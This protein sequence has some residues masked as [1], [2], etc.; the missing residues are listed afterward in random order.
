MIP[1]YFL[2]HSK[3]ILFFTGLFFLFTAK[4]Q[5]QQ[6]VAVPMAQPT[7]DST[8]PIEI[9]FARS[10][11]IFTPPNGTELQTLAGNAAVKQG[12]TILKGDSIVLNPL[13]GI[14]EVFGNVHI[15]DADIINTY[16]SYLK[17]L[18]KERVAY[19]KKNVKLT[20]G[21]GTLLTEDL[22][23]NLATGIASYKLKVDTTCTNTFTVVRGRT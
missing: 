2:Y 18:G 7:S 15:N 20:D 16:A 8:T 4:V 23:Y 12:N 17:Y 10:L 6:P 13:T 9:I 3:T 1:R 22:E 14:A 11:R 19:L 21:K 5:A